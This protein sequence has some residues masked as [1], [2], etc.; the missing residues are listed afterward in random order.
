MAA[1]SAR[2]ALALEFAL[3]G[4]VLLFGFLLGVLDEAHVEVVADVLF[5][6]GGLVL[7]EVVGAGNDLMVDLDALLGLELGGSSATELDGTTRSLSP[8]IIRP[9]DGHG[10]RNEKS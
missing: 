4:A 9:E 7:E 3:L 2:L 5:E 10:A 8:L 1:S 6:F